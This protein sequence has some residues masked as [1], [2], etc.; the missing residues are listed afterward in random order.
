MNSPALIAPLRLF[1][2]L[3]VFLAACAP[4]P[5]P[6]LDS[7]S[8]SAPPPTSEAFMPV[9]GPPAGKTL[10]V[11]IESAQQCGFYCSCPAIEAVRS[12]YDIFQGKIELAWSG[13]FDSTEAAWS[14]VKK[15]SG[16]I[17][18]YTF[19]NL[20]SADLQ[21]FAALPFSTPKG[22]V[23]IVAMDASG[24]ILIQMQHGVVRVGAG[25][26]LGQRSVRSH[27]NQCRILYIDTLVNHG[28]VDDSA[29]ILK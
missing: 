7:F 8:T 21:L 13:F 3:V 4:T 29:V 11:S 5:T 20:A 9:E 6:V 24:A 2:L 28:F 26:R 19:Y 27:D 12:P 1:S 10:F 14:A 23:N 18:L 25:E 16:T 22:G 15:E 17:G